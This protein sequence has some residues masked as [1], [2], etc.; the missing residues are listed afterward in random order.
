MA[1]PIDHLRDI[2]R[3]VGLP[4][5]VRKSA[6]VLADPAPPGQVP[7]AMIAAEV[8]Q[9]MDTTTPL[10]PGAP[11]APADGY[12]R[13]PRSYNYRAGYN[14]SGRPRINERVSFHTLRA[15]LDS[16]DVAQMCISHRQDSLRSFD[17]I[18][19]PAEGVD[20]DMGNATKLV[21]EILR[22]PDRELPFSAWLT[23]YVYDVLGFDAGTLYRIR[24]RGG[25]P[26]G[27]RVVDGTTI[28]PLLDAWG[29]R[30]GFD[31]ETG[32]WAPAYVQ[33][34]QGVTWNWLTARDLIYVP[35]RPTSNTPY[36]KAPLETVLINANTDIRFQLYFMQRFTD[37][38]IPQMFGVAPEQWTPEQIDQWQS[39]WDAFLK[40]NQD[41]LNQIRWVPGGSSFEYLN[42]SD[43]TNDFSL[44]LIR[45]T[46]AAFHVSP[47]ELGFTDQVNK[48]S[49]QSQEAVQDRVGDRPLLRHIAQILTDFIQDDLGVPL[50]FEFDTGTDDADA[51]IV[52]QTDKVYVDMG[53]VSV[54]EI[55]EKRYGLAEKDGATIPRY[56]AAAAGP[57]P[58]S[59]LMEQ[60]AA[61]DQG[62]GAP[63]PGEVAPGSL[64]I[65]PTVSAPPAAPGAEP[66]TKAIEPYRPPQTAP[67]PRISAPLEPE[68]R[69]EVAAFGRFLKSR[70]AAGQWRD[71]AFQHLTAVQAHRMNVAGY[72]AL[73]KDA[74]ELAV[75]GLAVMAAD[76]GRVLM[77]QRA[78]DPDD[79]VGGT[80]EFPG[81]HIEPSE[82]PIGAARREWS[83]EVALPAPDAP[84][85]ATWVSPTGV[86]GGFVVVVE[87]ES[88][89]QP[90]ERGEGGLVNPD[91]PDGDA[92]E[93]VAWWAPQQLVNNPAVRP[94]L[95]VDLSLVLG[96]L[97]Q[98][99]AADATGDAA[100]DLMDAT[101]ADTVEVTADVAAAGQAAIDADMV[102]FLE[103]PPADGTPGNE[104]LFK[105]RHHPEDDAL[106]HG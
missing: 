100:A 31:P 48:A 78:L 90:H 99:A 43:F 84:V 79:P 28:A 81:G 5:E 57:I 72:S 14:I 50:I 37:G 92:V 94:E 46:A 64:A 17:Y 87:D 70:R 58:L 16:Y 24:N 106:S 22:Y 33:Y 98:A 19:R 34:V 73:R 15:L 77:I 2:A 104:G 21:R 75:A 39:R 80:W 82:S 51:L 76:T 12:S 53:A 3:T 60:S 95:S 18:L 105:Q 68:A 97:N 25:A 38:N 6:V 20:V 9:G 74:G 103:Q 93:A 62:T 27:L 8:S 26:I 36:G 67:R 49:S 56:F 47:N 83:E 32:Q 40:G 10:G 65:E 45:K 55:R 91:D 30:P 4:T 54:S 96:A 63:L 13:T 61:V 11:L 66:V 85:V 71:F 52:A 69:S 41:A 88:C 7:P 44:F 59:A 86:Y 102:D 42:K 1:S 23:K 35:Y 29:N 89:C 101:G